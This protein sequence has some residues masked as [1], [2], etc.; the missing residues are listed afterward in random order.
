MPLPNP[1]RQKA[2]RDKLAQ[3]FAHPASVYAIHYACQSF[4]EGAD[5][6]LSPVCI[7]IRQ[8]ESG[9]VTSFSIAK[10]A[11]LARIAPHEIAQHWAYLERAMLGEFYEF[12]RTHQGARYVHWNM[13]DDR[14]GFAAL[15]HRMHV[16]NGRSEDIPEERRIDLV[17][18]LIDLYG[19]GLVKKR[20]K[21]EALA[22]LN[23]LPMGGFLPGAAEADAVATGRYR[24]VHGSTLAKVRIVADV[25]AR[26]QDRTLITQAGLIAQHGGPVRLIVQRLIDNPG[27]SVATAMVG[28]FVVVFKA[29]DW[30]FG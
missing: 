22:K 21:L 24:D 15:A 14:F 10:I 18:I 1:A 17:Q 13:R 9:Q 28:G 26:A 6:S 2:A 16:L 8:L 4:T 29:Y 20:A 11:E 27:Y 5:A 19:D 30:L 12:V 23:R 3:V 7:A 25:A